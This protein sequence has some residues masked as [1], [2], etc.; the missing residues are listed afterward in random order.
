VAALT[1]GVPVMKDFITV[2]ASQLLRS[3]LIKIQESPVYFQNAIILVIDG[4]GV[5][6]TVKYPQKELLGFR[7]GFYILV[8]E[9]EVS[10]HKTSNVYNL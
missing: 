10:G 1:D 9:A 7:R 4:Q 8:G 3:S 5:G 2:L 6:K